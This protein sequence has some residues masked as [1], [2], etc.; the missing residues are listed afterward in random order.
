MSGP[1]IIFTLPF[2]GGIPITE[3]VTNSWLVMAILILL[4]LFL[5]RN[6]KKVPDGKQTVAEIGVTALYDLCETTM[7]KDKIYFAPYIGT[8]FLF[9][10]FSN[11]MGL[12]GFRA[13]TADLNTTAGW[14]LILF[15]CIQFFSIKVKGVK[16]RV[17]G[18]VEPVPIM[19]PLNIVGEFSTPISIA[20]RLFGNISSGVIITALLYGALGGLTTMIFP[21]LD[22]PILA[23]GVPAV[24]SIYLDLFTGVL[25]AFIISMLTMVF[26]KMA[27]E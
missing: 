25:Q 9:C 2:F 17:K 3:T 16:A 10:I 11:L 15:G 12:F 23:L 5:T 14:A 13:P 19:L 4:A 8:L 20:F 1:K 21:W 7:G 27:M 22:I 26:I 18:F 24:L 6:L